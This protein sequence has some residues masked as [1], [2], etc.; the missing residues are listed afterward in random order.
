MCGVILIVPRYNQ[1]MIRI[2]CLLMM[3]AVAPAMADNPVIVDASAKRSGMGWRIS[4][5]LQH[6]DSGWEHFADGWEVRDM[7]G[8][9]L[10]LR[11][12]MHP[13][14]YEQP[15]TR[16]LSSVMIP[17]GARK[18]MIRARCSRAGWHSEEYVLHLN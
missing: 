16:S 10:G 18:V 1:I 2:A 11:E 7:A 6:P 13:H 9:R 4:V 17:D 5:T 12:L 15:F 3:F 8:N 14:E